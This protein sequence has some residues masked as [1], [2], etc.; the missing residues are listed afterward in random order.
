MTRDASIQAIR[1]PTSPEK[2]TQNTVNTSD[3]SAQHSTST[4]ERGIQNGVQIA[5]GS[6]Q[7]APQQTSSSSQTVLEFDIGQGY[8]EIEV[9]PPHV[10]DR[11]VQLLEQENDALM[12]ERQ[13]E[14][15]KAERRDRLLY[16]VEQ[17]LANSSKQHEEDKD[18]AMREVLQKVASIESQAER[19][20]NQE[21]Q[22]HNREIAAVKSREQQT[23][24]K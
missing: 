12:R 21:Q 6:T 9:I 2:G 18:K 5:D 14:M 3:Q 8:M 11:R 22:E 17:E 24:R 23:Y 1:T 20:I 19:H 16:Q 13:Q 7:H 15:M 10:E 4:L